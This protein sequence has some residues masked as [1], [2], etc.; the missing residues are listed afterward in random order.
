[1][2]YEILVQY[3]RPELLILVPIL[4]LIGKAIKSTKY[5][6]DEFI[7]FILGIL[8]IMLTAIYILSISAV[9]KDYQE[10]LGVIF[11]ILIQGICCAAASVYFHQM[12]KQRNNLVEENKS[13]DEGSQEQ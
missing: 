13:T 1:M 5:I 12:V 2:E 3:I 7:P 9:P 11:D 10:I 6:R 4:F 8:S